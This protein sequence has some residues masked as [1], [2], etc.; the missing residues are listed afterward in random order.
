MPPNASCDHLD[1]LCVPPKVSCHLAIGVKPLVTGSFQSPNIP[2]IPTI[3]IMTQLVMAWVVP[4]KTVG[5]DCL[6][7]HP[8]L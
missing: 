5:S 1:D 2:I 3:H 8:V 4:Y 7:K 6:S